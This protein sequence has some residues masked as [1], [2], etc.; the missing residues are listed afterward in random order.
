MTKTIPPLVSVIIP[1]Y[2][3]EKYI[4][5]A[6]VSVL[7]QSHLNLEILIID[8]A[9]TDKTLEIISEYSKND[10]RIV[11]TKLAT[12]SG[13]A[14]AR[15]AGIKK[16]TGAFIAF[17]DSDDKWLENKLEVQLKYFEEK[18]CAV[19]FSSYFCMD[20][21]GNEVSKIV[22]A[23]P[24]LNYN[25]IL[26]CNYIGNL[27][28]IYSV[29]KLGKIYAPNIRKRQDWGL[30]ISAIKKAGCAYGTSTPLAVYRE[31]ENSISSNKIQL[32][33]YNFKIYNSFLNF[34]FIKS[35]YFMLVFFYEYFCVKNNTEQQ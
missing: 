10:S 21:D 31:R 5:E 3:S 17:L 14:V 22:K 34:S 16:A 1:T 6:L 13:S 33:K 24:K 2:N 29:E 18:N 35:C 20:E 15:N 27:T 7:N 9:S 28:G 11:I 8:D 23:L 4:D 19:V 30:W 12:N 25:K 26:K 32:V